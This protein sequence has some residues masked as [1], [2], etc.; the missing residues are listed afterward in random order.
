MATPELKTYFQTFT[1]DPEG[2][3]FLTGILNAEAYHQVN[4]EIIPGPQ[5][6]ANM[7][8]TCTMGK[9]SGTTLA[10]IIAQFPLVLTA[11]IHTFDVIGPEF[12]IILTGGPPNT[13]VPIQAWVFLH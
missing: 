11:E 12:S 3:I 13:G 8:V 9:I 1:T 2:Q 7:T 10:Q 6:P 5:A 4:V